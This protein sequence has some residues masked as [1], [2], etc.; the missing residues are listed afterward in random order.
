MGEV[1]EV[2]FLM[3]QLVGGRAVE[4][5]LRV[6]LEPQHLGKEIQV[7][8]DFIHLASQRKLEVAEEDLVVLA[9]AHRQALVELVG[10]EHLH[11]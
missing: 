2:D 10:M 11:Q 3:P 5:L 7:D 1:E 6:P 9:V 8:L 4:V